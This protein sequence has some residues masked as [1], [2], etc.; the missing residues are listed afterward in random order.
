MLNKLN[1]LNKIKLNVFNA[2]YIKPSYVL[3]VLVYF[4]SAGHKTVSDNHDSNVQNIQE[5]ED[6]EKPQSI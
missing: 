3:Q 4:I 5:T 2:T 1:K 6:R